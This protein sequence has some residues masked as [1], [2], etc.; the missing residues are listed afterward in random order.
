MKQNYYVFSPFE[1]LSTTEF[2]ERNDELLRL[3][4]KCIAIV[5]NCESDKECSDRY[6]AYLEQCGIE[7]PCSLRA[8][9]L[10]G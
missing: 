10:I 7:S 9:F 5:F 6:F 4:A 8:T 2:I 3:R 1:I